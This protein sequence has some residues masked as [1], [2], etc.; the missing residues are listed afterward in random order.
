MSDLF[1]E[2]SKPQQSAVS[3]QSPVSPKSGRV[4]HHVA[5]RTGTTAPL[6]TESPEHVAKPQPGFLLSSLITIGFPCVQLPLIIIPGIIL[7]VLS[8][9]GE[10]SQA[11]QQTVT[12]T[13]LQAGVLFLAIGFAAVCG[14]LAHHKIINLAPLR[15]LHLMALVGVLFPMLIVAKTFYEIALPAWTRLVRMLPALEFIDQQ[16]TMELME[17]VVR[18]VPFGFTLFA[19][20]IVPG[21]AEE[22]VFRGII[23]RGLK[24][25]YGLVSGIVL[26]SILFGIAHVHPVH[27]FGVIPLGIMFHVLYVTTRSFWAP[28]LAHF[29]NNAFS[30]VG[31]TIAVRSGQDMS[32]EAPDLPLWLIAAALVS[33][34]AWFALLF[35]TRTKLIMED[36]REWSP[37]YESTEVPRHIPTQRWY[38]EMPLGATVTAILCG[39]LFFAAFLGFA[40]L[41]GMEQMKPAEEAVILLLAR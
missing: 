10:V 6:T 41:E 38:P 15:I 7:F 1:H 22:L 12:I 30:I 25:R 13:G 40:V 27:G 11:V 34:A 31:T 36:G 8:K 5:V 26:T 37:G 4:L 19:V 3:T 16:N 9:S 14:W 33:V 39:G 35:K 23:G 21:I 32:A 17:Q 20:A 28:V 24:A 29:L 2:A 18:N